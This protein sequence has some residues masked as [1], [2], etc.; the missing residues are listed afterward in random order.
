MKLF[1]PS[2][3]F[4]LPSVPRGLADYLAFCSAP[5]RSS[6]LETSAFTSSDSDGAQAVA[7]VGSLTGGKNG[8]YVRGGV[9]GRWSG[10]VQCRGGRVES[11]P[12]QWCSNR[13]RQ[14]LLLLLLRGASM[15]W[16]GHSEQ[17]A[18]GARGL[19]RLPRQGLVTLAWTWYRE[20]PAAARGVMDGGA[21]GVL[22]LAVD[23]FKRRIV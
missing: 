12:G 22:G 3:D 14:L 13:C 10:G 9:M 2:D 5:S 8:A 20:P 6:R 16:L 15:S 11:T 1:L 7:S 17:L 4:T 19:G 23:R 21:P 18:P